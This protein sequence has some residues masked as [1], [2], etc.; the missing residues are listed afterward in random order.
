MRYL[1]SFFFRNRFR[2]DHPAGAFWLE[3]G[4]AALLVFIF[5][6]HSGL[7]QG[8]SNLYSTALAHRLQKNAFWDGR[9]A[10]S[11]HPFGL[12]WDYIWTER[13]M[14]QN[15]GLGVPLL[16]MPFEALARS[17]GQAFFP[18][19]VT[20]G[21][22]L[23]LTVAGLS[24]AL[25]YILMTVGIPGASAAGF[26]MRWILMAWV[27][28]APGIRGL[29]LDEFQAYHETIFYGCIYSYFLLALVW[30][31]AVRPRKALFFTICLLAGCIW[32]IRVTLIV[33]GLITLM[34]ALDCVRRSKGPRRIIVGG[35]GLFFAGIAAGLLFNYLRFG[36]PGEPGY[37]GAL[38][39]IPYDNYMRHFG[40]PFRYETPWNAAREVFSGLFFDDDWHAP[41][42]RY[43][44]FYFR[45]FDSG[46][47]AVLAASLFLALRFP[48]LKRQVDG[49][50]AGSAVL[51]LIGVTW[52]FG[53]GA[54][55]GLFA[56]YMYA[57]ALCSR[58]M[59]EFAPAFFALLA[60]V[61]LTGLFYALWLRQ[62]RR[63]VAAVLGGV[64]L[65]VFFNTKEFFKPYAGPY[66]EFQRSCVNDLS[67]LETSLQAFERVRG[68]SSVLPGVVR[69]GQAAGVAGLPLQFN[70]W[71]TQGKCAVSAETVLFLPSRKC[72]VLDYRSADRGVVS[73]LQVKRDLQVLTPASIQIEPEKDGQK[74]RIIQKFCSE[75]SSPKP[76][77]LYKIGWVQERAL[78]PEWGETRLDAVSVTDH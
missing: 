43:R 67:T 49:Q 36:S 5:L 75:R 73:P 32:L 39:G 59:T 61:L 55:A 13:G 72:L 26:L 10:L 17:A 24:L 48:G 60:G 70:G 30:I 64:A 7:A 46:A 71:D 50:G 25:R 62:D 47:L 58:Y 21:V 33:Y 56:A 35:I 18:D 34:L 74:S 76:E 23:T 15:W 40:Y 14:H 45:P 6:Y 1:R 3:A 28:F 42:F 69:C 53:L 4:T 68:Q 37:A 63:W 31:Q 66:N 27:L 29:A 65:F 38:N 12:P 20:L 2:A 22:Y 52:T 54:T 78:T 19:R 41:M 9:L 51:R 44:F 77:A 11:D 16:R 57:P 8:F